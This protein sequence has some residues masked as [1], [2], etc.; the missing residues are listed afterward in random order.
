MRIFVMGSGY[1]GRKL[2]TS[3]KNNDDVFWIST[4]SKEK[5]PQLEHIAEKAILISSKEEERLAEILNSC[6]GM[7][8]AVAPKENAS[9]EET[10]LHTATAIEK[11]LEKREKPFYL[12]YISSTSVYGDHQGKSVDEE[13]ERSNLSP[14]TQ[15]LCQTEDVYLACASPTVTVCILRL[16]GIYGPEREIESRA[17]T[18]S[19]RQMAGSG[20]APTNHIHQVDILT[21]IEFCFKKRLMGV[22]N[23]ANNDHRSR[24]EIYGALCQ[25]MEITAPKWDKNKALGS[26]CVVSNKKISQLGFVFQHPYL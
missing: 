18:M 13:S 21:A 7:V 4:T 11:A 19:G 17:R 2:V 26:N 24:K 1:I 14:N 20:D 8:V 23:L 10:Y 6:D 25:K 22:Y 9:Y 15:V 16:A 5:L 3:W 12:L